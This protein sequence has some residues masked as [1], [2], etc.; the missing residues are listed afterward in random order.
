[1]NKLQKDLLLRRKL[2]VVKSFL[3]QYFYLNLQDIVFQD[4]LID[5]FNNFIISFRENIININIVF[6]LPEMQWSTGDASWNPCFIYLN[7]FSLLFN[8]TQETAMESDKERY[9]NIADW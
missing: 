2:S 7:R 6:F 8:L 3:F 5:H 4:I 1:M 9:F